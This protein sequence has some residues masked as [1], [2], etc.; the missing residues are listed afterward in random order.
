MAQITEEFNLEEELQFLDWFLTSPAWNNV[1]IPELKKR[2]ELLYN[3][4]IDPT[5]KRKE[6]TSDDFIRGQIAAVRWMVAWP[7]KRQAALRER[8]D[9]I[10]ANNRSRNEEGATPSHEHEVV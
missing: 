6:E 4:L 7:S 9:D 2:M 8:M 5:K 3:K 1:I 10:E